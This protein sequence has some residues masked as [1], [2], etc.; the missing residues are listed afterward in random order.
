MQGVLLAFVLAAVTL[1][2]YAPVRHHPFITIDD[3]GYVVNNFHIQY[4]NWDTVKWSFT[5]FHYSN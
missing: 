3:Y 5:S 1:V 2:V 4:L